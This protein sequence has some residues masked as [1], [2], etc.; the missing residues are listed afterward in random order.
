M[1]TLCMKKRERSFPKT[2]YFLSILFLT[3]L[4]SYTPVYSTV[5]RSAPGSNTQSLTLTIYNQGKTLVNEIREVKLETGGTPFEIV[6]EGVPSTIDPTSLQVKSSSPRFQI[7]D[8]NYEYDLINTKNLLE[9]FL[10]KEVKIVIPDPGGGKGAV[11]VRKAKLIANNDRPIFQ[12]DNEIYLG[13]YS[14]IM[15][16]GIPENLRA[17][18]ALVWLVKNR[19]PSRQKLDVSYLAGGCKWKADY[20]LKVERNNKKADLSGWVTLE[21]R[22]GMAFKNANLKLVAGKLHQVLPE[23]MQ[24]PREAMYVGAAKAK[25]RMREE[26]FFEYHLYSL[27]RKVTVKNNQTKQLSLLQALGFK[28]TRTLKVRNNSPGMYYSAYSG[29]VIKQHPEVYI[30]FKNSKKSGLGIPLPKGIVRAY[31]ESSDGSVLLIGEDRIKHT[32]K[33][34]KVSLKMGEAFDVTVERKQTNFEKL[35][36]NLV[37]LEWEIRLR[38]AKNIPDRVVLEEY[39][40]GEWKF[41]SNPAKFKKISS[42]WVKT[43]VSIPAEGE[44]VV[45]YKIRIRY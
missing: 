27:P 36:R 23:R 42:N 6:F 4:M 16:T 25:E 2:A 41:I 34:E 9:K 44:K 40:P 1:T 8:Q 24:V 37:E 35:G 18:P 17:R 14:S 15:L 26:R 13:S 39:L 5:L 19:G 45:T 33:N 11:M 12:I 7:L 29:P 22:S 31:Q 20:V 43:E 10:G 32:P 30:E 3:V 38:N 28:V 21:N